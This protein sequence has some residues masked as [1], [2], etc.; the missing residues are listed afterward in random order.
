MR[1]I[2]LRGRRPPIDR[3]YLRFFEKHCKCIL[4]VAQFVHLGEGRNGHARF[5]NKRPVLLHK[6][7]ICRL[8]GNIASGFLVLYIAFLCVTP[9]CAGMDLLAFQIK[10]QI[11]S[12]WRV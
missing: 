2:T 8:L 7:S 3:A 12:R 6:G 1:P 5:L 10:G 11:S 4:S 9:Q